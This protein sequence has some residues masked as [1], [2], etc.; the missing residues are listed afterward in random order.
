M[1]S[2]QQVRFPPAGTPRMPTNW[3]YRLTRLCICAGLPPLHSML[4]IARIVVP[5]P[6]PLT[7]ALCEVVPAPPVPVI[8]YHR[9]V[10]HEI[11]ELVASRLGLLSRSTPSA[12]PA[13]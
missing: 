10:C 9:P 2:G 3:L 7:I 8:Q 4:L 1:W 12:L 6:W 5:K 11:D 13:A